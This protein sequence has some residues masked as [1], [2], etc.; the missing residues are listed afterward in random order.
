MGDT[1]TTVTTGGMRAVMSAVDTIT[2]L[3]GKVWDLLTSNPLLTLFVAASL[4]PVGIALF[5]SLRNAARG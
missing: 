3:M 1:S 4:L 2:Q 5:T